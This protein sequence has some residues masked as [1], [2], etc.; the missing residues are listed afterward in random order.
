MEIH[1]VLKQL[2]TVTADRHVNR[3]K[4]RIAYYK[5]GLER[6]I[7]RFY[8]NSNVLPFDL[9]KSSLLI[10]KELEEQFKLVDW[11]K[12]PNKNQLSP[13]Q[14]VQNILFQMILLSL[15][16]LLLVYSKNSCPLLKMVD[17]L[18]L[19]LLKLSP[20]TLEL[21]KKGAVCDSEFTNHRFLVLN[22]RKNIVLK[23]KSKEFYEKR[24]NSLTE[25]QK[26]RY[27]KYLRELE[28]EKSILVPKK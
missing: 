14:E 28:Y 24:L 8:Y 23:Y 25:K 27:I 9:A 6:N 2:L 7:V 20:P 18:N 1:L 26:P 3:N 13:N 22:G 16:V 12:K 4:N 17:N 19:D 11:S 5:K 10:I 15:N 21:I